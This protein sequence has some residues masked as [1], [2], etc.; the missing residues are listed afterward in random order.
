MRTFLF[1]G[2][3]SLCASTPAFAASKTN[4][5]QAPKPVLKGPVAKDGTWAIDIGTHSER[6]VLELHARLP[7][8]R[9]VYLVNPAPKA[10]TIVPLA[11]LADVYEAPSTAKAR[12]VLTLRDGRIIEHAGEMHLGGNGTEPI[13]ISRFEGRG[14]G[15]TEAE[16]GAWRMGQLKLLMPK[17]NLLTGQQ[18][19]DSGFNWMPMSEIAHFEAFTWSTQQQSFRVVDVRGKRYTMNT[20]HLTDANDVT[21]QVEV[22]V[23]DPRWWPGGAEVA[24]PSFG[25]P[26]PEV[27]TL[28]NGL[29]K[30]HPTADRI[31]YTG[32]N[33]E[34]AQVPLALLDG[35]AFKADKKAWQVTIGGGSWWSDKLVLADAKGKQVELD[36][37]SGWTTP[38]AKR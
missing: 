29:R 3:L 31:L 1:I 4:S 6:R 18:W 11:E 38:A 35:K 17:A 32:F 13:A 24:E 23:D 20:L 8:A 10:A 30:I 26:S 7:A 36:L 27:R 25:D 14:A 16:V 12:W 28:R 15:L 9:E 22:K 5:K 21:Q 34:Q 33:R 37:A 2:V 19:S